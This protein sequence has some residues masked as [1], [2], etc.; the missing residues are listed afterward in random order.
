MGSHCSRSPGGWYPRWKRL[1]GGESRRIRHCSPPVFD[2]RRLRIARHGRAVAG[3]PPTR[4][5][6]CAR[7]GAIRSRAIVRPRPIRRRPFELDLPPRPRRGSPSPRPATRTRRSTSRRARTTIEV[8]LTRA[9]ALQ[10]A[11]GG[12]GRRRRRPARRAAGAP[13]PGADGGRRGRQRVPRAPDAARRGGHRGVR[14]PPLRARRHAR[15][16][17]DRDGR[18]R[19]PQPLPPV[20]PDQRV[21][22]RDGRAVRADRGRLRRAYGDRLSSAAVVDN[23]PGAAD[24]AVRAARPRSA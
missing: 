11:A 7:A 21:Q 14:Q 24:R 5:A 16:E 15:P 4:A 22:S 1:R 9:R 13:A 3:M 18:R 10:R 6:R 12:H 20:R 19:D 2:R 23:R 17:P 8:L